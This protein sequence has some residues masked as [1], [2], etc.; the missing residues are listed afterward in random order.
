[1]DRASY[2]LQYPK[3][4]AMQASTTHAHD[5]RLKRITNVF[6][7]II[8]CL[9]I[10]V[11]IDTL[12]QRM[13]D[14]T[15]DLRAFF[16][17]AER[18][19]LG[20]P[21]YEQNISLFEQPIQY[22]YPP[23]IAMLFVIFPTY[24]VAWWVWG[25]ISFVCWGASLGLILRELWPSI[26]ERIPPSWQP[27][28]F[29]ALINFTPVLSHFFWGQVQL[30]ILLL[31]TLSWIALQRQHE[32]LAGI[33]L[34]LTISIKIFPILLFAPLLLCRKWKPVLGASLTTI[35]V[36]VV[37][38]SIVG[39]E[40][41]WILFTE[42]LPRH[43]NA[44]TLSTSHTTFAAILTN[45]TNNTNFAQ[46]GSLIIRSLIM[47][48]VCYVAWRSNNTLL[49]FALGMS[50]LSLASPMVWEHYFV[51]AYLPWLVA[52]SQASRR[53]MMLLALS[54]FLMAAANFIYWAPPGWAAVAQAL[55]ISGALLTLGVQV[56]Q[57]LYKQQLKPTLETRK[58]HV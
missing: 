37:C 19:R 25:I 5:A 43:Q 39:W 47:L 49:S 29:A 16:A 26:R 46:L 42:L 17:G 33:G 55:P 3:E 9:F 1:V 15:A 58:Q 13:S 4:I 32:W 27:V 50:T 54:F 34:G 18:L 44:M 48:L 7:I 6:A 51:L 36:L 56:R 40:Q 14:D 35:I 20:L 52:L 30:Q 28:L 2:A 41:A 31:L 22:I 53:Q 57:I 11:L 10:V 45:I 12:A 24:E 8:I 38:Y 21:L 23:P